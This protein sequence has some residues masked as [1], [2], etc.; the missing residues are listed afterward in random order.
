MADEQVKTLLQHLNACVLSPL[1][2][3]DGKP[4]TDE[5]RG[6]SLILPLRLT[7]K[8]RVIEA[9]PDFL[10]QG[11]SGQSSDPMSPI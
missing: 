5:R 9:V 3:L 4:A 1:A 7:I 6:R 10:R 8:M 11:D 2:A